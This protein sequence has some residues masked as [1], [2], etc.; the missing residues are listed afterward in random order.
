MQKTNS[1][2]ARRTFMAGVGGAALA[3]PMINRNAYAFNQST[4]TYSKRAIDLVRETLVIDMLA[5]LYITLDPAA[6]AKPLTEKAKAEFKSSGITGF[7]HAYGLAGYESVLTY[8]AGWQ[9]YCGRYPD[10]FRLVGRAEDLD[11]A[12]ASGKAAVIMG[13][14]NSQHFRR[15]D[16]VKTFYELGQRCSQL[17][18]NSQNMIGSGSTE[19]VD[20]GVSDFGVSIIEAMNEV[21]MLVDVSHSGDQTTLD[22]VEL[23]PVP[24]A[25][26]HSNCRAISG[27]PRTK[28]DEAII[29][30]GKKD[31]V[32]GITGVRNF[33]SKTDP[34]NVGNIV[35]HIDHVVKLTSID[36][37][38]VGSDADLNGYDALPPDQVEALKASYKG[39]YAFRDKIDIDGF[40][41]PRK[42]FDLTEELIRR[43]YSDANISAILGGNFRRLL[44]QTWK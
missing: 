23:S 12:K 9:G 24:I 38:G 11:E 19:R 34:T 21:G 1:P 26:T 7:H 40:N 39:S 41:H 44:G 20:G 22:A 10:V 18:Y 3:F 43:N 13:V 33:V 31:G 30:L 14:Q 4:E 17:T 27:H 28:T 37:V 16:D 42:M 15:A 8:I 5:P 29:A 32:M 6:Y 36:N 35:D 25:Y 2:I